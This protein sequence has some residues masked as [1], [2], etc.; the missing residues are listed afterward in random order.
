MSPPPRGGL[1]APGTSGEELLDDAILQRVESDDGEPPAPRT[2]GEIDAIGRAD[3]AHHVAFGMTERHR[4]TCGWRRSR[5]VVSQGLRTRARRR[6]AWTGAVSADEII[7]TYGLIGRE[8]RCVG[9]GFF[10]R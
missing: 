5:S 10:L 3:A 4:S 8:R 9:S 2:G 7:G 6:H 1:P